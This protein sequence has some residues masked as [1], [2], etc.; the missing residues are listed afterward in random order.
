MRRLFVL[1]PILLAAASPA[2][3]ADEDRDDALAGLP[4]AFRDWLARVEMLITD[5][6]RDYF[7]TLDRDFR[8]NAFIE[9]FWEQRDPFD[10]THFNELR[11]NWDE[12]A[13][14][15]LSEFGRFDDDRSRV[16]LLNGEPVNSCRHLT[17]E[18][19]VWFY[20]ASDRV[21]H[22]FVLIFE[23]AGRKA[24]YRIWEPG[25]PPLSTNRGR[26]AE[27]P[28]AESCSDGTLEIA[29]EMIR[30]E[31]DHWRLLREI[32]EPPKPRSSEWVETFASQT[33]EIPD[34]APTFTA[35][36]DFAFP[37]RHQQRT[38]VQAVVTV[39]RSELAGQASERDGVYQFLVSGEVVLGAEPPGDQLF[40]SFRF[41]FEAPAGATVPLVFQRYLR[42]G[43]YT[44]LVKV[45]DLFG[46]RYAGLEQA[47]EVPQLDEVAT[48]PSVADSE[49]YAFLAE[50]DAATARG[51]RIL[52][53]LPPPGV[54]HTGMVRFK[55]LTVGDFG[56]VTFLLDGQ[57][58]LTKNRPPFSVE[59]DLGELPGIHTLRAT[60][61]DRGG[62]QAATDEILL[63]P[64]GQQFRVRLVEPQKGRK[65]R[66]SLRAVADVQ[67]PDG[68]TLDR[69]E[70]YLG[71]ELVATLYQP[72]W[73][74][75]VVL[76]D[77]QLAYMRAVAYLDDGNSAEELV[78]FNTPELFEEVEVRFVEL[79]ATV[80]DA[81]GRP[82]LGLGKDDFKV[83]EDGVAQQVRRFEWVSDL[84]IHAVLLIDVSSSMEE[85]LPTVAEAADAFVEQTIEQEDRASLITFTS[86]PQVDVR[87][88]NDVA[89]L[90]AALEAMRAEGSTALYDSLV[91]ALHYF[92]GI[93]GQKALLLLS[94]GKDEASG[95]DFDGAL[96]YARRAG[97]TVYAIGLAEASLDRGA[98]R[99]LRQLADETG[100][101]SFFVDD[102]ARLASIYAE[103]QEELRS[104]YLIAYQSSSNKDPS[105]FRV[106][107][108]Q[109]G[110][111]RDLEVRTMSG[112]YP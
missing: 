79:Y 3:G 9:A 110:G 103:I 66:H 49:L 70:L 95:F 6:E 56:R 83:L 18:L 100:G 46:R 64:G 108:V 39:P 48:V 43:R 8:R 53:L 105:E 14:R 37:G 99:V 26:I 60:A 76:P 111:K 57:P 67:V 68:E 82:V 62:E 20:A 96:A 84:P 33:A 109:V 78:F 50:A 19:E 42:P 35:A 23:R 30:R 13:A 47:I 58:I 59:L 87:F 22:N 80:H 10:D 81:A 44:V 101:R 7:L 34:G 77:E 52:R 1:L 27:G 75:P 107:S 12:R 90:S 25:I 40:E 29:V 65:Y 93:K 36:M 86:Q 38:V 11:Q 41:R 28:L 94:D 106:V 74:Q 63:N 55:T 97:V 45:E 98:R 31:L 32:L 2:T 4:Q 72:P 85:A 92:H 73:V 17:K 112:Y 16:L 51:E 21:D 91:F 5:E 71:E 104:Q 89:S 102:V 24:P 15:A 88:T 54:V 69:L 61:F